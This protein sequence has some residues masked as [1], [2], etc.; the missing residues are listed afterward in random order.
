MLFRK[1]RKTIFSFTAVLALALFGQLFISVSAVEAAEDC[2]LNRR[3][4]SNEGYGIS[5][6]SN[7][8]LY[9]YV[10]SGGNLLCPDDNGDFSSGGTVEIVYYSEENSTLVDDNDGIWQLFRKAAYDESSDTYRFENP[11]DFE[12]NPNFIIVNEDQPSF[13]IEH[14]TISGNEQEDEIAIQDPL[15]L[16][17]IALNQSASSSESIAP[18]GGST[19][20]GD[21]PE[22]TCE[23]AGGLAWIFC[24]LVKIVDETFSWLGNQIEAMLTISPERY[25]Q[26]NNN[27]QDAWEVFRNLAYLLLVPAMLV[28]LVSTALGF[29]FVSAYTVKKSL[30][31]MVIATI[32][33]A[34]SWDISV[35]LIEIT[36][37]IGL[38]VR[39]IVLQPFEI[40]SFSDVFVRSTSSSFLQGSAFFGA[41]GLAA[42]STTVL[43]IIISFVGT[44]SLVLLTIFVFLVARELFILALMVVAPLAILSWIFPGNTKLWG[45]WWNLFTKLLYIYPIIMLMTAIGLIFADLLGGSAAT[46]NSAGF[47]VNFAAS[48]TEPLMKVVAFVI[49]YALIPLAF[50]YVGGVVGNLAGMVNDKERGMFDRLKNQ[51]RGLYKQANQEA[52]AGTL[53]NRGGHVGERVGRAIG[54]ARSGPRGWAPGTRGRQFAQESIARG[55]STLAAEAAQNP[56]L[57]QF[58]QRDD[59]GN[60]VLALSGGTNAGMEAA[61]QDLMQGWLRDDPNL[62]E[63]AAEERRT[64]AVAAARSMGVNK[65]NSQVAMQ[66]MMQNKARSV[67]GGDWNTVQRGI[68]RLHG[69]NTTAAEQQAGFV[70]YLG[71]SAGR[72]DL[73]ADNVRQGA[74][75]TGAHQTVRGHENAVR[76]ATTDSVNRYRNAL[77]TGDDQGALDAAAEMAAY[78]N[79]LGA[80]VSEDNKRLVYDMFDNVGLNVDPASPESIDAQLADHMTRSLTLGAEDAQGPIQPGLVSAR[81][82]EIRNRAGLFERGTD[83]RHYGAGAG[84]GASAPEPPTIPGADADD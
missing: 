84:P 73:G 2:K 49:P 62:S 36:Q 51:R 5:Q 33:I 23:D 41:V 22:T 19:I 4:S 78:R 26:E 43:G 57:Q 34:L 63:E 13:G 6:N 56:E 67:G 28:M 31:R 79:A 32:F 50:K 54:R 27:L 24:P 66:T 15:D 75:R 53:T 12:G 35:L 29:E 39:G 55:R 25:T 45:S 74:G 69:A 38:G 60:A 76:A 80:D 42:L 52:K 44:A 21:E 58:G 72:A 40:T 70:Q 71:R 18:P 83:P 14:Y 64:R 59:H 46:A 30:P 9:A 65:A 37:S 20:E 48:I 8:F 81:Q 17:S 77:A 68:D 47:T 1:L 11:N 16:S 61:S 7:A 3:V 10:D 82:N